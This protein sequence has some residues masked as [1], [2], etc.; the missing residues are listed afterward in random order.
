MGLERLDQAQGVEG[1]V[2]GIVDSQIWIA[3][4]KST[5]WN[6]AVSVIIGPR[7]P[8]DVRT[9]VQHSDDCGIT[10]VEVSSLDV[11]AHARKKGIADING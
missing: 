3:E 6:L 2:V 10:A 11:A 7:D 1:V 5:A 9:L 4:G 8:G